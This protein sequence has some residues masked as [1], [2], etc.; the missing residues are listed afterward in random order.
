MEMNKLIH[1]HYIIYKP[2]GYLSQ[3]QTNSAQQNKK[4]LLGD[5]EDFPS[6]IMAVGRLDEKSEGL[7]LLTTDG[8]MSDY[9]NSKKVEKEYYALVD[10]RISNEAVQQLRDGVDIGIHGKKYTTKPCKV[11]PLEKTPNLPERSR[12]IRD[13]RHGPTTWLSII[14]REGKFRQVRKMTSAV[15]CP[16]LRLVRVRVGRIGLDGMHV[17]EV[18]EVDKFMI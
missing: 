4:K 12:K 11:I 2:Y 10:G 14:L 1:K 16:T 17:G 8:K 3:F 13:A 7:L 18:M 9:V 5:L 15:G 6:G